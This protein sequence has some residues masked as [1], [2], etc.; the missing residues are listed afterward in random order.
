MSA[1]IGRLEDCHKP[2]LSPVVCSGTIDLHR[3]QLAWRPQ[4]D[5]PRTDLLEC[6][7]CG[8]VCKL[9]ACAKKAT[10]MQ[11]FRVRAKIN[12]E[13]MPKRDQD[14][15]PD[16]DRGPSSTGTVSGFPFLLECNWSAFK[17]SSFQVKDITA[18]MLAQAEARV[19]CN[20]RLQNTRQATTGSSP[21]T[22]TSAASEFDSE[23]ETQKS[24]K[25]SQSGKGKRE[26]M[27]NRTPGHAALLQKGL[28]TG[29][30]DEGPV[31]GGDIPAHPKQS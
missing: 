9:R 8:H 22:R 26:E 14:R 24:E 21:S 7:T 4:K 1:P 2:W 19:A 18:R 30:G 15:C 16:R 6:L 28:K 13:Q 20:R 3:C 11:L 31:V 29:Q 27:S 25:E 23:K 17:P 10:S 12:R 5:Y